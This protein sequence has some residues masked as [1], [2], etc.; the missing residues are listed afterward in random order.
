MGT[1]RKRVVLDAE[2]ETVWDAVRDFAHVERLVPGFVTTLAASP[3]QRVVQFRDGNTAIERLVSVDDGARR[4]VYSVIGGR[5]IHNN[6]VVEVASLEGGQT[7]LTWTVD[8]LPDEIVPY[9]DANM[10][11]ALDAMRSALESRCA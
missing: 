7:S 5:T 9:L 4:L 8:A 10:E 6:S 2:V 1:A 3:A 11:Q